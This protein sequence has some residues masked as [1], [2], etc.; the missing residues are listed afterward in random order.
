M[1][2]RT[3]PHFFEL[4]GLAFGPDHRRDLLRQ[5]WKEI[6]N[7]IIVAVIL[8]VLYQLIAQGLPR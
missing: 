1:P 4:W 3:I 7:V 6:G 8:D 5:G 2:A